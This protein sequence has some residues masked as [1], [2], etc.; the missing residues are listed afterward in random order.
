L[1]FLNSMHAIS[2]SAT[3]DPAIHGSEEGGSQAVKAQQHV[4]PKHLVCGLHRGRTRSAGHKPLG[5]TICNEKMAFFKGPD[6]KVAAVEDFCPHRGAPLSLGK[7][8]KGHL[9]CGYHGLE[10]GC[11]GKTV[12]MPGQ[13]VRGFP[14]IKAMP[15]SSAMVLSGSGRATPQG[16]R[17]QDA[18]V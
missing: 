14:A 10:M 5:R 11:D 6:G 9:Q 4:H 15:W 1:V 3:L 8:C 7:V 16:R 17:I 2:H 13:R 18:G 12:H